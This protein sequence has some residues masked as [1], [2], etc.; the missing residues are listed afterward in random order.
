MTAS[1]LTS[2]L[3]LILLIMR[4]TGSKPELQIRA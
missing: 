3:I 2:E 4:S 1:L